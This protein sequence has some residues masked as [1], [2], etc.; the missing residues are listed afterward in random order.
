MSHL[1]R[2][3][4]SL[5]ARRRLGW[6]LSIFAAV[7][8]TAVFAELIAAD[9]PVVA[10]TRGRFA[11]LESVRERD[12]AA[13]LSLE[14]IDAEYG[15]GLA[16]WP[17]VRSSP[18]RRFAPH[19][20]PS[21]AHPLGTDALGRDI[22]AS[23][24]YGAR[25]A[26]APS[27]FAV[28]MALGVGALLGAFAGTVGG[29]WDELLSRP[30]EFLLAVPTVVVAALATAI[31]PTHATLALALAIAA[32]RGA[33]IARVVRVDAMAL[34]GLDH[35][36][37]AR[38]LGSSPWRIVR[39]HVLPTTAGPILVMTVGTLP[40]LVVLEASLAF[41]GVG[42]RRSWGTMIAEAV[43]PGGSKVAGLLAAGAILVTVAATKLLADA[44][45]E[46]LDPMRRPSPSS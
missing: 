23:L 21:R 38:A 4:G 15:G 45:D 29:A 6:V 25:A 46:A 12:R 40:S 17:L 42:T 35:V 22:V 13:S 43:A 41:L 20:S 32:V 10:V 39:R 18:E 7:A 26:L 19:A 30:L 5:A 33:E 28:V 36:L 34:M 37:A 3:E 24:A 2:A 31:A 14:A 9:L 16:I 11:L 8:L 44:L 27:L 1:R